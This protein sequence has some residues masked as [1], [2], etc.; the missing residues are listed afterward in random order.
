MG[1]LS[2]LFK[3]FTDFLFFFGHEKNDAETEFVS[4][5]FGG[6]HTMGRSRGFPFFAL[7]HI[8]PHLEAALIYGAC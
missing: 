8:T 3:I 7:A 2:G 1:R 4:G 6:V 5:P